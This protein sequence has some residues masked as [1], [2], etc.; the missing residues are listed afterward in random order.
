MNTAPPRQRLGTLQEHARTGVSI[1]RQHD[2]LA[3][4]RLFQ[5]RQRRRGSENRR[6]HRPQPLGGTGP[7]RPA[8]RLRHQDQ[9]RRG[10]RRGRCRT[11]RR[12]GDLGPSLHR[13]SR[14]AAIT[15]ASRSTRSAN[16]CEGSDPTVPIE[17]AAVPR[18]IADTLRR[19]GRGARRL[20]ASPR[21]A[22][23]TPRSANADLASPSLATKVCYGRTFPAQA[24]AGTTGV[25]QIPD[26][27]RRRYVLT[28]RYAL[29]GLPSTRAEARLTRRPDISCGR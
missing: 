10:G 26:L 24:R 21:F 28:G 12:T 15:S 7:D 9:R 1:G 5:S 13:R 18:R 27:Q 23:E 17:R 8:C 22:M 19:R 4:A 11:S 29:T 25:R 14:D 16:P 20:G 3:V 6:A 2:P